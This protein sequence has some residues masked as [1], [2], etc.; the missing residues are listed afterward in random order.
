MNNC[1][2]PTPIQISDSR[3]AR[4]CVPAAGCSGEDGLDLGSWRLIAVRHAKNVLFSRRLQRFWQD[5][6]VD[7]QIL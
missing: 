4:L 3:E 1:T 7:C 2:D 6:L 5:S